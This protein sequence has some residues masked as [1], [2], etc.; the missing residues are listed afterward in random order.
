LGKEVFQHFHNNSKDIIGTYH[1]SQPDEMASNNMV[2]LDVSDF[3]QVEAFVD[4]KKE[5]LDRICLINAAAI[6][7]DAFAHKGDPD[8]W[9]EVMDVNLNGTYHMI[10]ALLP[11]MRAQQYGRIINIS[12]VV[13]QTGFLGTS[14]YAASKSAIWGLTKSIAVENASKNILVN[15]INLGYMESGMAQRIQPDLQKDIKDKIPL[16]KFG[17]ISDLILAIEFLMKTEYIT[18]S[19]VD[20]NGGLY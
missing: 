4:Q 5:L 9:K 8:R 15:T 19:S 3:D 10:R 16:K 13:A 2:Q 12:S 18:G 1:R 14:A 17:P 6:T 20:I 7:Y 11:I